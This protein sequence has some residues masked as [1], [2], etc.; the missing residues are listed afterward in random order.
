MEYTKRYEI[1]RFR[2]GYGLEKAQDDVIHEQ[3][4]ELRLNGQLYTRVT[5]VPDAIAEM[6]A[7]RLLCD[8]VISANADIRSLCIQGNVVDVQT[9]KDAAE[10]LKTPVPEGAALT[11]ADIVRAVQSFLKESPLY[12]ATGA[13][14]S[15]AMWEGRGMQR[16][17]HYDDI[18]RK[19]AMDKA[20]GAAVRKEI[21]RK[22]VFLLT[23]GRVLSDMVEKVLHARIGA[24]VSR[25]APTNAAVEL[26]REKNILLCGF[27]RGTRL[28]VYAGFDR[29]KDE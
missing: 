1:R 11:C 22:D 3:A 7:G 20:I 5:C 17:F 23:S 28:N 24:L 19:N 14:H 13:V 15:C 21:N 4:L 27:A 25:S 6:T 8:G 16:L 2:Q 10:P 12:Q 26:A 18:G 9:T 29:I